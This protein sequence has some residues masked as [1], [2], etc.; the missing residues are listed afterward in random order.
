MSLLPSTDDLTA[1]QRG[2][3]KVLGI[4]EDEIA[5][6]FEALS[7]DTARRI[8]TS[9]YDEPAPPSELA[10][11]LDLS[12][13]NVS[14]HLENI[15]DAGMV[16]VAETRYSEKGKEMSVY[17]PADDPVAVFVGTEE[18]KTSF[19]DLLKRF[20]GA[21][22]L[23]SFVSTILFA[24]QAFGQPGGAGDELTI[25]ELLS[26]PGFEFLLGGLFIL[27]LSLLWWIGTR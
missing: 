8:L 2:E 23:L 15:H 9:I 4:D 27:G 7:S 16:Q 24:L 21:S 1:E 19:R 5:D 11:R 13:Q 22:V 18:R 26:F 10:N 6:V 3:I 14:Y 20:V 12:L 25:L 17:A